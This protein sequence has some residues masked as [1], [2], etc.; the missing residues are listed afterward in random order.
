MLYSQFFP[1]RLGE[2]DGVIQNML[3]DNER[4]NFALNVTSITIDPNHEPEK[5]LTKDSDQYFCSFNT[6]YFIENYFMIGFSDRVVYPSGYV[7]RSLGTLGW[8]R[9]WKLECSMLNIDEWTLL[10]SIQNS[11]L[12]KN[13]SWFPIE[14]GPCRFFKITQTQ[15]AIGIDDWEKFRMRI[16][17]LEFFGISKS[18]RICIITNNCKF[19]HILH[20]IFITICLPKL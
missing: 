19:N 11:D 5:I 17:Y 14:G 3:K 2:Y 18:D 15:P 9:E 6:D 10:H 12:L 16:S 20:M 13:Y 8:M 1:Y 7:I 4:D